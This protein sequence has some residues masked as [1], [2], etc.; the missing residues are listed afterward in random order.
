MAVLKFADVARLPLPGDNVAIVSSRLERGTRIETETGTLELNATV[1]EGHRFA[2]VPI[3]NGEPVLSWNLPFGTAIS[4]IQPGQYICNTDILKALSGRDIDVELPTQ[5]NFESEIPP[6]E[7]SEKDFLPGSPTGLL[8]SQALLRDFRV[9]LVVV[10]VH[11]TTLFCWELPLLLVVL[12]GRWRKYCVRQLR[13]CRM[14]TAS[15]RWPTLRALFPNP[16]IEK[17]C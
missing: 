17:R 5:P 7:L 2:L 16:T 11:G 3:A 14:W 15:W 10:Q 4:D 13:N 1:L 6:F 8:R 9:Q 12:L